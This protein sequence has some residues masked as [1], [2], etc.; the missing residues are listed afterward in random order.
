M[1]FEC[2]S[3]VVPFSRVFLTPVTQSPNVFLLTFFF[4][5]TSRRQ[6]PPSSSSSL[7][8]VLP[9]QTTRKVRTLC[10]CGVHAHR[11]RTSEFPT[12]QYPLIRLTTSTPAIPSRQFSDF[13][14]VR[15][16]GHT[17]PDVCA[18]VFSYSCA[19]NDQ[20]VRLMCVCGPT[21]QLLPR[22]YRASSLFIKFFLFQRCF[23]FIRLFSKQVKS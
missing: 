10:C 1:F 13:T 12:S 18:Y 23:A 15:F 6:S 4:A 14:V 5:N 17:P 8:F 22:V 7:T 20:Q 9:Q 3:V 11:F 16:L 21:T 19:K 2:P